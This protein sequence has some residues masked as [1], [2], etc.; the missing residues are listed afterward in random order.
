MS[1]STPHP[2]G[3]SPH[4]AIVVTTI[5]PPTPAMLVIAEGCIKHGIKF[6]VI[7]DEKSPKD[8]ELEGARYFSLSEQRENDLTY[9]K[10]CPT[11]HY[12]RKNIG[13]LLAMADG[14][15]VI[16]ETDDDNAPME[17]FWQPRSL[18]HNV[19]TIEGRGWLNAYAYF[20]NILIWPRGLPLGSIHDKVPR[21]ETLSLNT[22]ACP[23]QQGLANGN[24]DVD[25]IY[26]LV[27]PLP[28]FFEKERSV[29]LGKDTWCPFNSQNTT[30]FPDAYELMYLPYY[31][32]FRMTDIWRSFVAQI[33]SHVNGWPVLF[34][35]A[36]VC[37]DRNDHDLMRD[38]EEEVSGY[39]NNRSIIQS[40]CALPLV[41]GVDMI[42]QNMK[43]CYQRLVE[44]L[45]VGED[46]L[47]LL[48]LWLADVSSIRSRTFP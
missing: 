10:E 2:T 27:L 42:G 48:D 3:N 11:R 21:F 24:P 14:V 40:L 18:V 26:R 36:T 43:M 38:F 35:E 16:I 45:L 25:A 34:H 39:L 32:S 44:M 7:G 12:A 9:A 20:T 37:Q 5:N 46:E 8:F 41:T 31:C 4:A 28:I 30:F 6:I 19:A 13:Y 1:I 15:G 47:P 17:G 29:A 23:I 33:I 22:I